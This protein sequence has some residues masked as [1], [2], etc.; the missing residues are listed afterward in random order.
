MKRMA[1]LLL[2]IGLVF[3]GIALFLLFSKKEKF[4]QTASESVARINAR[5]DPESTNKEKG[6][7]FE[8]FVIQYIS[9][10]SADYRFKGKVSDYNKDGVFAEENYEPDLKFTYNGTPFAVECK[11]RRGYSKKGSITWS[12]PEQIERYNAYQQKENTPVFI[13]IGVGGTSDNPEEFYLVPLY[14]LTRDFATKQYI[15]DFKIASAA[16]LTRIIIKGRA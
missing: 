1:I 14:R 10:S 9:K 12:Y 7:L 4:K 11:W 6:I 13:A 16:D 2:I 15:A 3:V 8:D 5:E